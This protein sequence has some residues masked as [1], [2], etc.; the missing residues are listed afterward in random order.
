MNHRR[1]KNNNT[2]ASKITLVL[3]QLCYSTNLMA[4][5]GIKTPLRLQ[6][7]TKLRR[8]LTPAV[9]DYAS[10]TALAPAIHCQLGALLTIVA[11]T[12]RRSRA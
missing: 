3:R 2:A 9:N 4:P 7:F 11:G 1:N 10:R 6:D 5:V 8:T 12:G